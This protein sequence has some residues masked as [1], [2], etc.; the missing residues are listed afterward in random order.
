MKYKVFEARTINYSASVELRSQE[1][2]HM[3]SC[4]ILAHWVKTAVC[5][6]HITPFN[7]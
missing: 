2:I 1:V 6:G 4:Y 3:I 5:V 7:P